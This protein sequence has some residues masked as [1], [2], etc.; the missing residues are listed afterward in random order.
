MDRVEQHAE[1]SSF[2]LDNLKRGNITPKGTK[3]NSRRRRKSYTYIDN[4][5]KYIMHTT[6]ASSYT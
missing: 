4:F 2:R 5:L 1:T 6:I 3:M